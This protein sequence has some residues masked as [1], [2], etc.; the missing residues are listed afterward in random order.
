MIVAHEYM[1][2]DLLITEADTKNTRN[3]LNIYLNPITC[4]LGYRTPIS[5]CCPGY[6]VPKI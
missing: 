2:F 5:T 1:P 6:E 3:A 4:C